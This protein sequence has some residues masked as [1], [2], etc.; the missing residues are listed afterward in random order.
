MHRQHPSPAGPRLDR[1]SDRATWLVSRAFA[2]SSGLLNE[3]FAGRGGGLRSYHYRLLT[4]LEQWGPA[5]QATLGR[6]TGIDRSD[7]TAGITE[8]EA[9]SLVARTVD[10]TN[11]RRNIVEIT[12]A[13]RRG[14]I[15]LDRLIDD[16]QERFLAPLSTTERRQF[17]KIMRKL[18]APE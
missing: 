16:V 17:A 8:L 6:T 13:G 11:R 15:E 9:R 3:G 2:R 18:V 4:A 1:I 7:V 10:S 5:S 14:L 12:A